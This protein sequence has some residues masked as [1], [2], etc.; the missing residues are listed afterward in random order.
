MLRHEALTDIQ[1]TRQHKQEA[2]TPLSL[3]SVSP[4]DSDTELTDATSASDNTPV[5]SG[6]RNRSTRYV[7]DDAE[8]ERMPQQSR[9][10]AAGEDVRLRGRRFLG[11]ARG[12]S[13]YMYVWDQF[14]RPT[15]TDR[16]SE[17]GESV[18]SSRTVSSRGS[19]ELPS[20]DRNFPARGSPSPRTGG[21]GASQQARRASDASRHPNPTPSPPLQA[22]GAEHDRRA[23]VVSDSASVGSVGVSSADR[24]KDRD[25][26]R[27]PTAAAAQLGAS[28][29][30]VVQFMQ[31]GGVVLLLSCVC[32]VGLARRAHWADTIWASTKFV[33]VF[34][35]SRPCIIMYVTCVH[36]RACMYVRTYA[37]IY[38][39]L[40][41]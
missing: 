1:T 22:W 23:S 8:F 20:P 36:A 17:A 25:R 28:L 4:S 34:L 12:R 32:A 37:F 11:D 27:S 29:R 14:R 10:G 39:S 13:E 40:F 41:V 21:L 5:V 18:A 16:L 9:E 31:I 26:D 19:E 3:T 2:E 24:D 33:R 6:R 35:S 38:V 30:I 7:D 15:V